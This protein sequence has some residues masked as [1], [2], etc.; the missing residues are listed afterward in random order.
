M[1]EDKR[2]DYLDQ[3]LLLMRAAGGASGARKVRV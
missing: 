2:L 1:P 3:R